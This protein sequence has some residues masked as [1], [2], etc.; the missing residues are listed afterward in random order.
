MFKFIQNI[1]IEYLFIRKGGEIDKNQL[2]KCENLKFIFNNT[3][4]SFLFRI[5]GKLEDL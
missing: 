1:N 3:T 5:N 2:I 4:K